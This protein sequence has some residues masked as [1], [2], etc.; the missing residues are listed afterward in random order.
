[1]QQKGI[2]MPQHGSP[3][4]RKKVYDAGKKKKGL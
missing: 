3:T 1:M 4:S 2:T